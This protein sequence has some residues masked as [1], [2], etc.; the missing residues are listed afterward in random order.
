MDTFID[1][2]HEGGLLRSVYGAMVE[3]WCFVCNSGRNI[4][5][6]MHISAGNVVLLSYLA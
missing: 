3:E 2:F 4:L 5:L 1:L 6:V